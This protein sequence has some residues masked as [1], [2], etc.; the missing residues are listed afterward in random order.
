M[1]LLSSSPSSLLHGTL[2][3]HVQPSPLEHLAPGAVFHGRYRVVRAIAT[4]S[5]GALYEVIDEKTDTHRAL[6]VMLPDVVAD[7][8]HRARFTLEARVTGGIESDHVVRVSD[9]DVDPQSGIPFLVMDLLR[10]EDLGQILAARRALS[11]AEVALYLHQVALALDK[12]HAAGIVHRD[13]KPDNLFVT[14]RDDGSPC[15]KILDFGIAKVV[16]RRRQAQTTRALGTPL[17]MSPEQI[18]GA[19]EIGPRADLYALGQIAY[20]LLVGEP[21][22]HEE[23]L[24][25]DSLLPLLQAV[26]AGATE[27]ASVRARRRTGVTLPPAFDGWFQQA[28]A[29]DPALRF[30]RASAAVE[31]LIAATSAPEASLTASST[32]TSAPALSLCPPLPTTSGGTQI[33]LPPVTSSAPALSPPLAS[34]ALSTGTAIY[35]APAPSPA[36]RRPLGVAFGAA[37]IAV[38]AAITYFALHAPAPPH[39]ALTGTAAT[40]PAPIP[41]PPA[42][43]PPPPT[44]APPPPTSAPPPPTSASSLSAASPWTAA[45]SAA[46][47][48]APSIKP[49]TRTPAPHG[50]E[51]APP[52]RAPANNFLSARQ[53]IRETMEAMHMA[54]PGDIPLIQLA[55]VNAALAEPFPLAEVLA[56]EGLDVTSWTAAEMSWRQRL[57]T[58]DALRRDYQRELALA[59]DRLSRRV[60]PLEEELTAWA[61]LL[62]ALAA[63]PSTDEVLAPLELGVNDLSRLIRRWTPRFAANEELRD[64]AAK[65]QKAGPTPLPEVRA[66]PRRLLASSA[67]RAKVEAGS[68]TVAEP[69]QQLLDERRLRDAE[70]VRAEIIRK[71]RMV[72]PAAPLTAPT[73]A[74]AIA[75]PLRQ[76]AASTIDLGDLADLPGPAPLPFSPIKTAPEVAYAAAQQ[77][78]ALAQPDPGPPRE[79][80]GATLDVGPICAGPALPFALKPAAERTVDITEVIAP[81]PITPFTDEPVEPA[82]AYASAVAHA[83]AMQEEP[84]PRPSP[85]RGGATLDVGALFSGEKN[86][87]QTATPSKTAPST[88]QPSTQSPSTTA[89]TVILPAFAEPSPLTLE[90]YASLVVELQRSP[91]RHAEILAR[92]KVPAEA[93]SALEA[94][95]RARFEGDPALS[96]AFAH[97]CGAYRAY[98]AAYC[99]PLNRRSAS[100]KYVSIPAS[101]SLASR[102]SRRFLRRLFTRW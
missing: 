16:S 81:G 72:S 57:A 53:S 51:R 69:Q 80:A 23:S 28:I 65:L 73:E 27:P 44:S 67:A 40:M 86:P 97:A 70:Q 10:G 3:P 1:S 98:L 21:Y 56:I 4:G 88:A 49:M 24:V 5:M 7:P 85:A 41:S 37:G 11:P 33:I 32:T 46:L 20:A 6:K 62:L 43:A 13:L 35:P 52:D 68:V 82:V 48:A 71:N 59:E 84:A 30:D 58:D 74:T 75:L 19:G 101:A 93:W 90:Q 63:A 36:D 92:Y 38:I 78:A 60:S 26:I 47:G 100:S 64:Q 55:A 79:A 31:A 42:S 96:A 34:P 61:S 99:A 66:E 2:G 83:A 50:N 77:H 87:F 8:D 17:Y 76:R 18:R 25:G 45:S 9:A 15:V 102:R 22:W 95:W 91:E 14:R 54:G 39:A 94:S 29:V 89:P 12:T